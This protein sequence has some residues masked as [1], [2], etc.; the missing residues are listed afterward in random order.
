M[1]Y[2]LGNMLNGAGSLNADGL[3][4]DL[5]FATD[6]T[7]TARKGPTPVFT[8]A[9]TATFV[10]S[11]GLIQSAA[12]NAPRFDHDPVT[13]ASR[14]LLIEESR[15]NLLLRSEEF[16]NAT[17]WSLTRATISADQTASP[18]GATTADKFI[19]DSSVVN[20]HRLDRASITLALNTVYTIS[21]FAKASEYSGFAMGVDSSSPV[22]GVQFSLSGSGSVTAQLTGY[23]GTIQ[24]FGNGWFRCTATFTSSAV[25]STHR[26]YLYL[27]QNGTTFTYTGDGTSGI[28]IYG[29]QLEAGSFPTSYI[30]TVASSVVRSADVCS[31]TGSDFSGFYNPVEGSFLCESTRSSTNSN[32]FVVHAS[33]GTFNN[34]VDLRY[35]SVVS[36]GALMNV[37]NVNQLMGIV[38]AT[39]TTGSLVKQ[40]LAIKLND[41]A[42]SANGGAV[43]ADTLALIPAVNRLSI[44]SATTGGSQY[45]NGTIS[46]IRYFRKRLPNAKLQA[47]TI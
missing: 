13:L 2:A 18:T 41:C 32:A 34:G 38:G 33:D 36:V 20:N 44:G 42:Y 35:S 1:K 11:N 17:Y 7:L 25:L 40:S 16:D 29:A 12:V 27:G 6:K 26:V 9:S 5:Q 28:F 23:T 30:P 8:R 31:I 10:G 46:S 15:T 14:G 37:S 43:S 19:T 22:L 24:N 3:S 21:V 39:V 45:I 47:L 4:L